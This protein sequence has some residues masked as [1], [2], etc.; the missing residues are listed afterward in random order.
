G[1][2]CAVGSVGPVVD[3]GPMLD[4]ILRRPRSA[5]PAAFVTTRETTPQLLG[6][7]G[8]PIDKGIDRLAPHGRQ[9]MFVSCLQ[10]AGNLLGG[11][12]LREAVDNEGPEGAIAF[13]QRFTPPA[14]LIGSGSVKRRVASA[15][16][17]IAGEFA[18]DRRF[19]TADR[20]RDRANRMA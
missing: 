3:G 1:G 16:Q 9:T 7:L 4:G 6:P 19:R 2:G 14:Q 11:P 8:C 15:R 12:P 17:L 20:L 5:G 10:P 18:R 13:D